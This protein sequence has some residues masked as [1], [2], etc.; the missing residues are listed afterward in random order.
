MK[1]QTERSRRVQAL[2]ILRRLYRMDQYRHVRDDILDDLGF[3]TDDLVEIME[4][5]MQECIDK[6][7]LEDCGGCGGYHRPTF[8][9]DCRNDDE[10][11]PGW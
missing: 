3:M 6:G 10:R 9:G 7:E 11:F 1:K 2:K 5:L 8:T 4:S